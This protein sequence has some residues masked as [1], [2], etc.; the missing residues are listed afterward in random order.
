MKLK[1]LQTSLVKI[2]ERVGKDGILLLHGNKK[3]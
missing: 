2:S 3:N 1:D